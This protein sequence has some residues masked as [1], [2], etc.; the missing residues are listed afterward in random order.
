MSITVI[1]EG[2]TLRVLESSAPIP[3]GESLELYTMDEVERMIVDRTWNSIPPQSRD[4]LMFQTQSVSYRDWMDEDAWDT[5]SLQEAT[6]A[7][8]L[9][10]F[11]P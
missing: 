7:L 2:E 5:P 4:D 11:Q 8:P 9:A 1:A 6:P 10:D 3:P